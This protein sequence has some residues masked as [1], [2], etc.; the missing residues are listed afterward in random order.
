MTT[1]T[2]IIIADRGGL[3]AY[4]V[5]ETPTR[6]PGLRL[7]DD[8]QIT[9]MERA[10]PFSVES[11]KQHVLLTKDWPMLE[12]ETN[13]RIC[14]WLAERIAKVV[15]EKRVEGWSFAAEPA[16]HKAIV[17]LL[18]LPIRERIVE[19]VPSDLM[20]TVSAKLRPHFRSL[21]PIRSTEIARS[22]ARAKRAPRRQTRLKTIAKR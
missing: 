13:C 4:A 8:F 10:L 2:L 1:S 21:R 16:I 15:K 9:G 5:R 3:K 22:P 14:Q 17:D 20:K 19:H 12:M 18:P 6:G 11:T 7:V